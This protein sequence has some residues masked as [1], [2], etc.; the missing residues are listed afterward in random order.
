MASRRHDC[1]HEH[2]E[3]WTNGCHGELIGSVKVDALWRDEE[4]KVNNDSVGRPAEAGFLKLFLPNTT[5]GR[6]G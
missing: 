1:Y 5:L 6:I 3:V 2:N 4:F